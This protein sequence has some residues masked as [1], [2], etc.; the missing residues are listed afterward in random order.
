MNDA[1]ARELLESSLGALEEAWNRADA[2]SWAAKCTP[3][4]DFINLLGMYVKGRAAVE[5][6]HEKIYRG[7]YAGS[8][9][10]LTLEHLR[11]LS[12]DAVVAIVPGELRVPAGPVKGTIRT[13]A[14]ML[15]VKLEGH[16]FV[17]SFQNTKR[18]ATQPD[19]TAKMLD[20]FRG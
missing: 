1:A 5:E 14:T 19:H 16:W 17:A 2:T 7:P 11:V 12:N 4:V 8:T 20:V 9:L 18:E 15:F 10:T 6:I 3:D 13:V